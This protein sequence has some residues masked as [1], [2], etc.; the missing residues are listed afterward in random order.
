MTNEP[1]TDAE[2][3]EFGKAMARAKIRE[4]G[5]AEEEGYVDDG[6]YDREAQADG[7]ER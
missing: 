2:F 4:T 6:A 3:V 5:A 1:I 7:M